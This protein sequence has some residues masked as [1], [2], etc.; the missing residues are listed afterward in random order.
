M[1]KLLLAMFASLSLFAFT[2]QAQ[3]WVPTPEWALDPSTTDTAVFDQMTIHAGAERDVS[4]YTYAFSI[5]TA[6]SSGAMLS[7]FFSGTKAGAGTTADFGDALQSASLAGGS[8][9]TPP[10]FADVVNNIITFANQA[11]SAGA[12]TLTVKTVTGTGDLGITDPL[13]P[14]YSKYF[15]KNGEFTGN[16]TVTQVT[17]VPE[18]ETWAMLL[19][20]LGAIG[21][22]SR[23]GRR[24]SSA[25]F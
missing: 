9:S 1:N 20:G 10:F 22:L 17:A 14:D 4:E 15:G 2:A 5:P 18:P 8:L 6:W 23:C 13:D 19:A 11:L 16:L 12:Y 24:T 7:G 3:E 21:F 25:K